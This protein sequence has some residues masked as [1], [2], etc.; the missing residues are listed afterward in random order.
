MPPDRL[1]VKAGLEATGGGGLEAGVTAG[2]CEEAEYLEPDAS[3]TRWIIPSGVRSPSARAV[4]W[5]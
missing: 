5:T 3:P 2:P 1:G 4:I